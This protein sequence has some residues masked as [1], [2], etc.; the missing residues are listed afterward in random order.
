M[1][2]QIEEKVLLEMLDLAATDERFF[3][4]A[5][6]KRIQFFV[7][8]NTTLF[9][10]CIAGITKS[11]DFDVAPL[12]IVPLLVIFTSHYGKLGVRSLY[13]RMLETIAT[14]AKLEQ[15]LGLTEPQDSKKAGAYWARE[16]IVNTRYIESRQ[17]YLSSQEF[18]Q[19]GASRGFQ[20]TIGNI[21]TL[22]QIMAL[23][24]GLVLVVISPF[25]SGPLSISKL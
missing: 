23:V 13:V 16:A 20:K 22:F 5:H 4:D 3:I 18:I 1:T 25:L 6:Q 19:Q 2:R 17:K 9:G 8:L 15:I 21:F 10:A 7:V 11:N 24:L 14:R 12:V